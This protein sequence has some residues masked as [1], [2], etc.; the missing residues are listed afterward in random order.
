MATVEAVAVVVAKM[1]ELLVEERKKANEQ[2]KQADK[3]VNSPLRPN[4]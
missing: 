3:V 2:K 1:L 4:Q